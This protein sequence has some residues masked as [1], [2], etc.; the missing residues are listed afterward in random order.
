MWLGE[1]LV[2]G[3]LLTQELAMNA[4]LKLTKS[5][6]KTMVIEEDDNPLPVNF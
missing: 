2:G 5:K 3:L 1:N 4:F 6:A